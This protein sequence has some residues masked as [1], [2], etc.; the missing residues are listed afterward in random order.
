M[1]TLTETPEEFTARS[2]LWH[3]ARSFLASAGPDEDPEKV[4]LAR[5]IAESG[6]TFFAPDEALASHRYEDA[7]KAG[8]EAEAEKQWNLSWGAY[9]ERR[10]RCLRAAERL[11]GITEGGEDDAA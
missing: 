11:A 6:Y 4:R 5:V 8:D 2:D 9:E 10:Q 3:E 7:V 1:E